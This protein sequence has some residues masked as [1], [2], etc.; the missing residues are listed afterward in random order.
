MLFYEFATKIRKKMLGRLKQLNVKAHKK[1]DL[2]VPLWL[3]SRNDVNN[4]EVK[5][6]KSASR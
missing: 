2:D 3:R 5:K 1:L 6:K 4:V